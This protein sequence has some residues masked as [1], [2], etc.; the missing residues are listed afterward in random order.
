MG[1]SIRAGRTAA[2]KVD[3]DCRVEFHTVPEGEKNN[4][5]SE[6]TKVVRP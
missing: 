6:K 4:A 2:E 1:W 5:A 3:G